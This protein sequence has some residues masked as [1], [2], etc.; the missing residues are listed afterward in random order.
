MQDIDGRVGISVQFTPAFTGM[1][2]FGQVLFYDGSTSAADLAGGFGID[3][4]ERPT[5][6]SSTQRRIVESLTLWFSL[7][8]N[9]SPVRC[10]ELRPL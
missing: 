5:G 3:L 10:L 8:S 9:S 1:P 6:Y 2:A 7:H 4:Y